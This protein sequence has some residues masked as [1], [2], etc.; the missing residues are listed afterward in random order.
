M[1]DVKGYFS[2]SFRLHA[3]RE[4]NRDKKD[5]EWN[6]CPLINGIIILFFSHFARCV[7]SFSLSVRMFM[8]ER[9]TKLICKCVT[10]VGLA[11]VKKQHTSFWAINF[12]MKLIINKMYV[13][14]CVCVCVC[15]ANLSNHFFSIIREWKNLIKVL[16]YFFFQFCFRFF[17]AIK[18]R[19]VIC[20]SESLI[21]IYFLRWNIHVTDYVF[22]GSRFVNEG[23]DSLCIF[24]SMTKCNDAY[25]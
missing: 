5:C 2:I 23:W 12:F 11:I 24:R 3:E 15:G 16:I 10:S 14:V 18:N 20:H 7:H 8:F 9:V 6:Q 22:C 4:R 19:F 13:T 21:Y 25:E 1:F 17:S